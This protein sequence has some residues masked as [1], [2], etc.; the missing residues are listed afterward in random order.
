M[1]VLQSVDCEPTVE[2]CV[3]LNMLCRVITSIE[4]MDVEGVWVRDAFIGVEVHAIHENRLP[5]A[6]A[7]RIGGA[8]AERLFPLEPPNEG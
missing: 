5:F 1:Q 2:G 7:V 4:P 3:A 8:K 6:L